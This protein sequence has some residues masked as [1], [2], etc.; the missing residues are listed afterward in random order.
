MNYAAK[1]PKPPRT[2]SHMEQNALLKTSGRY[3]D[4]FR[5]H[6]L[7]SI[8]LGT[9]LRESEIAA[10]NVGDVAERRGKSKRWHIKTRVQLRVFK[11]QSNGKKLAKQRHKQA[12]QEVFLPDGTRTK[13]RAFL[14][15]KLDH[16]EDCKRDA[17]LL[18]TWRPR[19]RRLST[20]TL[21]HI[22][23]RW[24][25]M[26]EFDQHYKFHDLRHTAVT[27]I[28]AQTKDIRVAQRHARHARITTTEIYT[29]LSDEELQRAVR[30]L[31]S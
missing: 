10:L 2:L 5:D 6:V 31:P 29:H 11:G 7:F 19:G 26:A 15:W 14:K 8:A 28:Y 1:I 23:A 18:V 27:N 30:K 17:P 22:F 16:G 12:G 4:T 25:E 21:R 13:L 9:A 24:Q 3:R 20:R